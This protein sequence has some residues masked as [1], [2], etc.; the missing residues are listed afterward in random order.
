MP[1]AHCHF[2]SFGHFLDETTRLPSL[3]AYMES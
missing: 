1:R 2:L 3:D